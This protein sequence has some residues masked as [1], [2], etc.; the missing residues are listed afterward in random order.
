M[1]H[2]NP[3]LIA[4]A[5][6]S[7][8]AALLH[9]GCIAFGAS[10][11]RAMGAGEQMARM[12]ERGQAYPAIVT[13]GIASVLFAWALYALSGAG[14]IRRLPLLRSVLWAITGVYLLRGIAGCVIAPSA[15]IGRTEAFWW[16]SSAICLAIGVV[17][18]IGMQRRAASLR[19]GQAD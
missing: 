11:Y 12:A 15:A 9:L 4:A 6:A 10:W 16:W 13:L 7:A 19:S 2:R 3:W 1:R 17:H 5:A 18:L 8:I 14:V